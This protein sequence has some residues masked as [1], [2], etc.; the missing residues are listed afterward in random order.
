MKPRKLAISIVMATV[1][2][3]GT[4]Q[5]TWAAPRRPSV[6]HVIF[7]Y[8][9]NHRTLALAH[10]VHSVRKGATFWASARFTQAPGTSVRLAVEKKLSARTAAFV[11][12]QIEQMPDPRDNLFAN[13]FRPRLGPG[14]Y[15]FEFQH[16]STII[17]Q[18]TIR[19][20]R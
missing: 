16:G 10:V 15:I 3:G 1:M 4:L 19:I 2:L 17:A 7:G 8:G 9:I 20:T 6:G 11:A 14:T 18:G 12:A 5:T 13:S